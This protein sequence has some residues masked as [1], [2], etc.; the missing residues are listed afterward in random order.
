MRSR[1]IWTVVFLSLACAP[2]VHADVTVG[3]DVET[4]NELLPALT[5]DE[6]AV[7]LGEGRTLDVK[8]VDLRV[9]AL[10]PGSGRGGADQLRT[11]LTLQ[12]P[13]LGLTLPISP[14]VSL[15]VADVGGES[16]LELRFEEALLRMPLG[17]IDLAPFLPPLRFP[18]DNHWFVQGADDAVQVR[19]RLIGVEMGQKVVRLDF[20]LTVVPQ[21]GR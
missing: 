14:A 9:T 2:A 21:R 1:W 13:A 16:W 5:R 10:E 15:G 7:P 18:A 8:L 6:V 12:V 19:S 3:F 4:L 20:E 17:A 11:A